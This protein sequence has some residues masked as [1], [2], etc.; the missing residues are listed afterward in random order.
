MILITLVTIVYISERL[1]ND[2]AEEI[3]SYLDYESLKNSE[4]VLP[5]WKNN[6]IHG[7][8]WKKLLN[9]NVKV[10]C[11]CS[12]Y[13]SIISNLLKIFQLHLFKEWQDMLDI[14]TC[15]EPS[16]FSNEE[17]VK[18][19]SYY[20]WVCQKIGDSVLVK[21]FIPKSVNKFCSFSKFSFPIETAEKLV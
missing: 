19:Y 18:D 11:L 1:M 20:R 8:T 16:N 15:K 14:L 6:I 9:R 2:V 5:E 4:L 12:K 21:I 3:F 10:K 13:H 17:T 7:K